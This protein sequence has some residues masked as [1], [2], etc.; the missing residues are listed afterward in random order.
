MEDYIAKLRDGTLKIHALENDMPVLD[1]VSL[2]RAF[3]SEET[4]KKFD[5]TGNFTIDI[6]RAAR[7]NCENMIG[8]V[9]I[10]LGV[11]GKL[12]VNGEYAKD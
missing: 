8:A 4:G 1:A 2:R 6:E 3:I 5:K 11:A 10:P 12:K 7:K 9:Q